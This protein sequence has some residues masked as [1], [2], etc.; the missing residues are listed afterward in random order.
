MSRNG[1]TFIY[2][3]HISS[4]PTIIELQCCNL[5]HAI[6]MQVHRW[7][8]SIAYLLCMRDVDM[9][10][11]DSMLRRIFL[12]IFSCRK[13]INQH[14]WWDF[15]APR[16]VPWLHGYGEMQTLQEHLG[17]IF[18]LSQLHQCDQEMLPNRFS[19]TKINWEAFSLV[20]LAIVTSF[21]RHI[22]LHSL[23][24][25]HNHATKEISRGRCSRLKKQQS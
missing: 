18:K 6:I 8:V 9:L 2:L 16:G 15:I 22:W 25:Y 10:F 13:P 7:K 4:I 3:N 19:Y 11:N 1:C 12:F 14:F 20:T 24:F 23:D 5:Q 17:Y 21:R